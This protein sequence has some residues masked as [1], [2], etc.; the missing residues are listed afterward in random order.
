MNI[1]DTSFTDFVFMIFMIVGK[2]Q[3]ANMID[4]AVP[5]HLHTNDAVSPVI[6]ETK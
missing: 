4:P 5:A 1:R 6:A 3:N 2:L